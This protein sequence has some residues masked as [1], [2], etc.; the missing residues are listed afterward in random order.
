MPENTEPA[1]LLEIDEEE[2]DEIAG[3]DGGQSSYP[4]YL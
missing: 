3:G 2:L 4:P 1:D